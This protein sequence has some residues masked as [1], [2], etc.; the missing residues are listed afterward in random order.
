MELELKLRIVLEGPPP[1]VDFGLQKGKGNAYQTIQKQRSKGNDLFFDCSVTVKDNRS[2]GLPNFL[3]PLAQGPSTARFIYVDVGQYAGQK[4]T[5]WSRRMKIPL[6]GIN[7]DTIKQ[8][9]QDASVFLE[10]RLTG[11]GR[12]GGP[13]CGTVRPAQ[14][15]Q[16][17]KN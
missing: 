13:A 16:I 14:G 12:D 6:T 17:E 5:G 2:D 10:A 7:W 3:G 1:G 11:T 15:W 8:A 4:E 9:A